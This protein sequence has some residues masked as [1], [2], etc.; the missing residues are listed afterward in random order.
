MANFSVAVFILIIVVFLLGAKDQIGGPVIKAYS[1]LFSL[2]LGLSYSSDSFMQLSPL[3]FV[4]G[5]ENEAES[6]L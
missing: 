2:S 4:E 1:A 6:N 3:L 5:F